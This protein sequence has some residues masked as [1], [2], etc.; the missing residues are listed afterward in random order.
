MGLNPC[1]IPH[2]IAWYISGFVDGEGSFNISL[3]KKNDYRI[4]WQP[5]LSFNVSQR[6]VTVLKLMKK[7]FQ[8]GIIK[9]RKDDLHSYDVT[10]P[11]ELLTRIIPFFEHYQFIAQR[12]KDN[13]NLFKQ[14][15]ILMSQKRHLQLDGFKELLEIR[16]KIN[17]GKGRTRKY[18]KEKV[19][20]L[21]VSSE[22]IRQDS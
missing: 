4:G 15:V 22:T 20:Q 2:H 14:A 18:T 17:Q 8:C 7:Y 1:K 12:K 5:V 19:L 11:D 10:T 21:I 6:E 16:E 13:F 9:R 3:R